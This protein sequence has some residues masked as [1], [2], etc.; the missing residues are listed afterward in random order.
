MTTKG[1]VAYVNGEEQAKG[2]DALKGINNAA[3]FF[4]FHSQITLI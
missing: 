4:D 3:R 1:K 2:P